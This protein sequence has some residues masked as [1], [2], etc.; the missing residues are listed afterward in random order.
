MRKELF[1]NP[2]SLIERLGIESARRKR[3]AKLRGTAA[4]KL[5]LGHIDSLELLEIC[6]PLGLETIYDIG[7]NIGTWT[8][9]AKALLPDVRIHAFEPLEVCRN[10]FLKRTDSLKDIHFHKIALASKDATSLIY[11]GSVSDT[12]SLL[13]PAELSGTQSFEPVSQDTRTL[14][15][16]VWERGI[17]L[18]DMLKLDVQGYELEVLK[19]A[20]RVLDSVKAV[21][22]EVSFVPLYR[23]QCLF[24]GVVEFMAA[25]GFAL[26]AFGQTTATGI[27][28]HQTDVLFLRDDTTAN[29]ISL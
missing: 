17:Q 12:T 10:G 2:R 26:R 9:L 4:S 14:D 18:P 5:Q 16:Y 27:T 6:R 24:A 23:G 29:G 13:P 21:I 15:S 28:L 8:V 7:A 19:G 3:L 11:V 25:S 1:Y 20:R 22:C